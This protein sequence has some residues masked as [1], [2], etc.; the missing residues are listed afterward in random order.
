MVHDVVTYQQIQVDFT[1]KQFL[2]HI[3]LM[4]R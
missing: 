2:M 3:P 4:Y 1:N